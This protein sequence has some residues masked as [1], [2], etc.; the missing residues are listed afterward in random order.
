MSSSISPGTDGD[1]NCALSVRQAVLAATFLPVALP[2]GFSLRDRAC[3]ALALDRKIPA[4]TA[5]TDWNS[6]GVGIRIQ[7][8]R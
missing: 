2:L 7:V 3:L 6:L 1:R 4:L 8:I 5:D